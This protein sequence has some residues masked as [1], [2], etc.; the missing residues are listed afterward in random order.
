M[1]H[2]NTAL[3]PMTNYKISCTMMTWENTKNIL[4]CIN[5]YVCYNSSKTELLIYLLK[6]KDRKKPLWSKK[7]TCLQI[8]GVP[9]EEMHQNFE[10]IA[11][12]ES[13]VID[14]MVQPLK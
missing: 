12:I 13:I 11:K 6:S 7:A 8:T 9:I 5:K 10:Q 4:I 14:S 1:L 2:R 3:N